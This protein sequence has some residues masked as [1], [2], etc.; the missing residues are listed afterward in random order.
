MPTRLTMAGHDG[1]ENS[2]RSL[3]PARYF[4]PRSA[5]PSSVG[6]ESQRRRRSK[7]EIIGGEVFELAAQSGHCT[8]T[9][10]IQSAW[11]TK[12]GTNFLL[13]SHGN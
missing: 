2:G 10:F 5:Y 11:Q 1:G 13:I 8:I 4:L 3:S 9:K 6:R 12:L 7:H